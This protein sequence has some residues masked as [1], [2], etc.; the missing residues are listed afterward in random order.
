MRGMRGSGRARLPP[1]RRPLQGLG[2]LHDRL[3]AQGL[4]EGGA[5]WGGEELEVG[6]QVRQVD[7]GKE[8]REALVHVR[9][10]RLSWIGVARR[11]LSRTAWR[12]SALRRRPPSHLLPPGS[13]EPTRPGPNPSA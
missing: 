11:Q 13:V 2:L 3:R 6:E 10:A 1:G 4:E 8:L 12:V 9:L 7:E 5:R